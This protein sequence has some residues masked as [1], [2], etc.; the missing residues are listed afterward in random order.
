MDNGQAR[1]GELLEKVRIYKMPPAA[2]E[3]LAANP[4]L[5]IAG[6]TASGKNSVVRYLTDTSDYRQVITHTT[7]QPREEDAEAHEYHFVNDEQ[8]QALIEAQAM[9]EVKEIHKESIY[10][11]SIKAYQDV[12]AAGYKPVLIIDIQGVEDLSSHLTNLRPYF[13]VPL[14]FD[15]WIRMMEKRGRMSHSERLRRMHSARDELERAIR[16]EHFT[17]LI[18]QDIPQTA[19]TISAGIRDRSMQQ[20]ALDA[21]S[22]LLER[23]KTL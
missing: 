22:Q 3:L 4:P 16:S 6:I 12:L 19:K 5:V 2:Q 15:D 18:N 11:T 8:M 17:L 21:A 20:K 23:L 14:S 10:G 13:L 7:R 1:R 9:I